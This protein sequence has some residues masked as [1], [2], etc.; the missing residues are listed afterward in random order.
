VRYSR[1][2]SEFDRAIGFFDATFALALTL[3]VTTLDVSGESSVWESLGSLDDEVGSQFI[4]FAI[5]FALIAN[6][7]LVHHRLIASFDALD[8]PVIVANLFLIAAIVLLP[9]STEAVGD[10]EIDDLALPTAV[11]ALDVAAASMMLTIIYWLAWKRD[12]LRSRPSRAELRA[13]LIASV[14]PAV[15]FVVSIPIA[16]LASAT[17]AKLSWLSLIILN[18]L[19]SPRRRSKAESPDA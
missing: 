6:Y 3:L 17:A 19:S 13:N 15:I 10:P 7:W 4:A 12:L 14:V 16:Y 5:A 1:E 8:T 2:E 9:F 11:F 18:R